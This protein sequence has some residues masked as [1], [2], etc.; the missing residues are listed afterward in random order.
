M[1]ARM[2][3]TLRVEIVVGVKHREK[4]AFSIPIIVGN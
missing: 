4:V 2:S 1:T 3:L